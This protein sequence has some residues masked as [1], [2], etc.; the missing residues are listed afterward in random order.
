[1]WQT[2]W[3]LAVAFEEMEGRWP[4]QQLGCTT[5]LGTGLLFIPQLAPTPFLG[6]QSSRGRQRKKQQS[7]TSCLTLFHTYAKSWWWPM[8]GKRALQHSP[9][10]STLAILS[11]LSNG[12]RFLRPIASLKLLLFI[13][14]REMYK[15]TGETVLIIKANHTKAG[16]RAV[17]HSVK[18]F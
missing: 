10:F 4:L 11:W 1:M 7:V 12:C 6:T 9:G 2:R 8:N 18:A 3:G 5:I 17:F 15:S 13:Q 14:S 16:W